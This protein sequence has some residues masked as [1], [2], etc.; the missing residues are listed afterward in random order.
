MGSLLF[1]CR[2]C[3]LSMEGSDTY[4]VCDAC[5]RDFEAGS[6]SGYDA[7]AS[8]PLTPEDEV[9]LRKLLDW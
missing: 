2:V 5:V 7:L 9:R 8:E 6:S 3:G 4:V 1:P